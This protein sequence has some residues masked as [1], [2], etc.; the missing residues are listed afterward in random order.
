MLCIYCGTEKPVE[1][2]SLE[3]VIPQFLGG[4]SECVET[5]TREVCVRCNSLCGRYVDA[6]VARGFFQNSSE[7]A[8]WRC[9]FDY[10][11]AG[12]NVFPLLY[13]GASQ[14]LQFGDDEEAEVWLAPDGGQVWHI[15]PRRSSEAEAMAGGDP[16]LGRKEKTGRVFSFNSSHNKYWILSNL[17]SVAAHFTNSPLFLGA[18][19][20][21]EAGF[22]AQRSRGVYCQK[23]DSALAERDAIL[24]LFDQRRPLWNRVKLDLLFDVRFLAKLALGFGHKLLGRSFEQLEYTKRLRRLLWTR[25]EALPQLIFLLGCNHILAV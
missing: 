19:S 8:A 9:C 4:N 5:I 7:S 17:K 12:G 15:H 3:H 1:E 22:S 21:I 11:E 6:P 20:N 24:S 25:R 14:E 23:D 18:D 10:D 13:F 2:F 16:V